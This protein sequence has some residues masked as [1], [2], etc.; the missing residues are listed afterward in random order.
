MHEGA[1]E[2]LYHFLIQIS[3]LLFLFSLC[4]VYVLFPAVRGFNEQYPL[5]QRDWVQEKIIDYIEK[6]EIQTR[7]SETL[8]PAKL[9]IHCDI[10]NEIKEI[11][12]GK[13]TIDFSW[14]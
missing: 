12:I 5:A 7:K 8:N 10:S 9:Q 14:Q 1:L 4:H 2:I 11:L 6:T 13:R 3:L